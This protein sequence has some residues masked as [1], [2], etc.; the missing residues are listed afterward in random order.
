MKET[1]KKSVEAQW[2]SQFESGKKGI[3]KVATDGMESF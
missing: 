3:S 1:D 2:T